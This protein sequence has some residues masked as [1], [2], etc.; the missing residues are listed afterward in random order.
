MV[1]LTR[2]ASCFMVMVLEPIQPAVMCAVSFVI[3]EQ[4]MWTRKVRYLERILP[5]TSWQTGRLYLGI[6]SLILSNKKSLTFGTSLRASLHDRKTRSTSTNM[7]KT[8]FCGCRS[9]FSLYSFSTVRRLACCSSGTGFSASTFWHCSQEG[10]TAF[11]LQPTRQYKLLR[12]VM[13]ST[14]AELLSMSTT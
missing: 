4:A 14:C 5:F 1:Y 7:S 9:A 13:S 3:L 8:S 6:I 12:S 11:K 2:L 10:F